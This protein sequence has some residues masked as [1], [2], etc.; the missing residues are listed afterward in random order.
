MTLEIVQEPLWPLILYFAAILILVAGIIVTSYLLGQ[1]HCQRATHLPYESGIMPTG[2]VPLRYEIDFY[3]VAMFFVIFDVESVFLFAWA[4]AVRETGW[5]GYVGILVFVSVLMAALLY[6]WGVG[7]L[8]GGHQ[9]RPKALK[10]VE[11]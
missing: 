4:V 9:R 11:G 6:L 7:A 8:D 5:A 2:A 1:R 10:R 3:L